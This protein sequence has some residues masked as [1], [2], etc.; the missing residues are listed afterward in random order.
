MQV[1]GPQAPSDEVS[2]PQCLKTAAGLKAQRAWPRPHITVGHP[3][4]QRRAP[5]SSLLPANTS[6]QSTAEAGLRLNIWI[7]GE[8]VSSHSEGYLTQARGGGGGGYQFTAQAS[9]PLG[10]ESKSR[11][12]V[13]SAGPYAWELAEERPA[14]CT[15][16]PS[17][18]P[19][20]LL[21]LSSLENLQGGWLTPVH[22][23]IEHL[24]ERKWP[25][26]WFAQQREA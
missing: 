22:A 19:L 11:T 6:C 12:A 21:P 20:S 17:L 1:P 24:P 25:E 8:G 15:A 4:L 2:S 23:D 9:W 26:P 3:E 13:Q 14:V 18:A 10:V 5:P 16:L 7:E